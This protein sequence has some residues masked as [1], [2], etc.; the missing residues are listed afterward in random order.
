MNVSGRCRGF[1]HDVINVFQEGITEYVDN[2]VSVGEED[3][4]GG[5][6]DEFEEEFNS[7]EDVDDEIS[8]KEDMVQLVIVLHGLC[9]RGTVH[10]DGTQHHPDR[11]DAIHLKDSVRKT[12]TQDTSSTQK[13]ED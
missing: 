10:C 3:V 1:D 7:E 11:K 6:G 13:S 2:D 9:G 5:T 12:Q 8:D 4:F